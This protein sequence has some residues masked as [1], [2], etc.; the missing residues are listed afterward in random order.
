MSSVSGVKMLMSDPRVAIPAMAM[1]LAVAI[2]IQNVNGM[3]DILWVSWLGGNAVGGLGLA[4]PL[5]ASICGV[6]NG[7]AIGV[8]AAIARYVGVRE[9]ENASKAAGQSLFLSIAFAIII[10]L[11]C[12][13]TIGPLMDCF[14]NPA[15]RDEAIA[16]IMPMILFGFFIVS[17]SVMSGILRGEGAARASMF[18]QVAGALTNIVLDPVFI[19]GM[20]MGVAGAGWATVIAGLVSLVLGLLCY[21]RGSGMYV[22]LRVR[23]MVPNTRLTKEILVV[24]LPQAAEYVVMSVI[25]IPMNYIIVG[26]AGA[27]TVGVYTSAWRV[28][29][30]ALVP[31]QAY[32]GAV[33]S[34][35]SAEYSSRHPEMIKEA[36]RFGVRR[37]VIHTAYLSVVLALLAYPLAMVFTAADDLH[38]LRDNMFL[39]FIVMA[40]MLPGMSQVFVGSGFLQALKHSQT[41]LWSSLARNIVMVTGYLAMAVIF[42]CS[43]AIW[44]YMGIIEIW[45]GLLMA[46]L[47][48]RCILRFERFCADSPPSPIEA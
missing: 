44:V 37:S 15:A 1:P 20:H 6:G 42:H 14:G 18:I 21:R 45:G 39:L 13:P 17:G 25:N 10:L 43:E 5:Y 34:V 24:G 4:Y 23:D 26:V 28:A 2:L 3:A 27:D 30:V 38:Y 12:L 36:Y 31:A 35:C 32:S 33:V 22:T 9:R 11:L 19:Y 16:Y 29:Y 41:A 8:A 7:L 46:W 40:C 47:A 48:W